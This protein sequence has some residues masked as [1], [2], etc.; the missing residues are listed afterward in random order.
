M[1]DKK[2]EYIQKLTSKLWE[3]NIGKGSIFLGLSASASDATKSSTRFLK[4]TFDKQRM[5]DYPLCQ[6]L[7]FFESVY[8]D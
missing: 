3:N 6:K 2:L 8:N 7:A 4:E 1:S 5:N